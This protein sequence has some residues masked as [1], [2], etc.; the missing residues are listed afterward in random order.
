MKHYFLRQQKKAPVDQDV[1]INQSLVNHLQNKIDKQ[2]TLG[3]GVNISEA[4]TRKL[5]IDLYLREAGWK[6]IR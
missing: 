2:T 1:D 6:V 3:V 4:E 5:Y